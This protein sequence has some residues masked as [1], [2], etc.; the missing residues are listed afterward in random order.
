MDVQ[1]SLAALA[2][3]KDFASFLIGRKIDSEVTDKAI[4]FQNSIIEFQSIIMSLQAE[5][6]SLLQEKISI[7]KKLDKIESWESEKNKYELK[8]VADGVFV[9]SRILEEDSKELPHW[10]CP[11]CFQDKHKSILQRTSKSWA[12]TD[13]VCPCCKT[14]ITDHSDLGN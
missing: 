4:A 7:E 1:T 5:N 13:Y 8:K 3:A 2:T 12:G 9:Y 11:N 6:H 14:E 10:L